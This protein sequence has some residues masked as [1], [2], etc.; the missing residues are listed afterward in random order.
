MT[1]AEYLTEQGASLKR[2]RTELGLSLRDVG[3]GIGASESAVALWEKGRFVMSA[4]SALLLRMYFK[5]KWHERG[6]MLAAEYQARQGKAS[7]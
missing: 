2:R 7:A 4:Y 6:E 5:R 1:R 3:D